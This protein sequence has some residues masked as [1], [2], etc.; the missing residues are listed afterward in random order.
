M[1]DSLAEY[2]GVSRSAVI[3]MAIRDKARAEGLEIGPKT[4]SLR[5]A[6]SEKEKGVVEHV[7]D[8]SVNSST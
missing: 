5:L 6:E 2:Y 4:K 1:L 7:Q 3:E 8:S